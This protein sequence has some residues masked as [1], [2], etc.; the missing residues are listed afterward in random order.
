M[1]KEILKDILS[2]KYIVGSI[3]NNF[4]ELIEIIPEIKFMV[5]FEHNHPHHILDVWNHTLLALSL[6]PND[7]TV[8]MALLLHDIEKTSSKLV[9]DGVNHFPHHAEK[10][11]NRAFIILYRLGFDKDFISDVCY[12]V[13]NH[14]TPIKDTELI[15][16]FELSNKLF[17]VQKCD[18][19]AH[20]PNKNK[21]RLMYIK[22]MEQTF[23]N[24]KSL[25]CDY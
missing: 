14:D 13:L 25:D 20:N 23:E 18:A 10:S 21:K 7:L 12:I 2:Q 22:K 24:I 6:S 9:K 17:T 11:A 16:K 5:G 8:R 1:Q 4:E 15:E 3:K 19:L